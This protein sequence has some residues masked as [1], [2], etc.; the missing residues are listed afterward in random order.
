MGIPAGAVMNDLQ[1]L[2]L[3][4]DFRPLSR[5]PLSSWH[6]KDAVSALVLQ[7]VNLVAE[8]DH[9]IRSPS[10]A[11]RVPSVVALKRYLHLGGY[12]AF[13]RFNIYCRDRWCCQYCAEE[14]SSSELTFD[15]V[16]PRSRGGRTTWEN[17][18]TA[19][20]RCNLGK[21]NRTPREAGMHL[22]RRPYRPSR[23]ELAHAAAPLGREQVHHSWVDFLYWDSELEA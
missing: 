9:V 3:N 10:R 23:R 22:L 19:C 12:P 8:Y 14:F 13:T 15:H 5:F 2:V 17:V 20:S 6:W 11:M 7:R 4:A 18:V 21:A 1:T 16:V